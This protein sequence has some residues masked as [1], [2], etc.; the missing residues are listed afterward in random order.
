MHLHVFLGGVAQGDLGAVLV[1][2]AHQWRQPADDLQVLRGA[3]AGLPRAKQVGTAAGNSHN[4]EAGECIVDGHG[5]FCLPVGIELHVG[6]PQQQGIEQLAG[7]VALAAIATSGGGFHAVVAPANDFHLGSGGFYTPG[8]GAV[9]GVQG[10]PCAVGAQFKQG[11]VY[12]GNGHFGKGSRLAIG[13]LGFNGDLRLLAYLVAFAVGPHI[14]LQ[15]AVFYTDV[16]SSHAHAECGLAQVHHGGGGSVVF[17]FVAE[18]AP[19]LQRR[20]IAPGKEAVPRHIAQ[21]TTQRHDVDVH[22]GSPFGA[23]FEL[24]RGV[25]PVER[26]DFAVQNAFALYGEQCGGLSEGHTH[27]QLGDFAWFVIVF[28]GQHVHAV[29]VVTAK[30]ELLFANDGDGGAGFGFAA[31]FIAGGNDQLNFT[32]LGDVG[33][34]Q[35]QTTAV[36]IATT[37][38]A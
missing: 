37:D 17:A 19:P 25:L 21:A 16:D 1:A 31:C 30:P 33:V 15:G 28:F 34:A 5:D 14:D 8:A 35:Q 29:A 11:F 20:F 3:D 4:A 2:F 6:L 38:V 10:I 9:H 36:A 18:G 23:D 22:I 12:R 13:Q 26:D 27:L 24:Y 32:W 7:V